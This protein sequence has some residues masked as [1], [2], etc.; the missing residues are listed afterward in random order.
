[1]IKIILVEDLQIVR[2]SLYVLLKQHPDLDVIAAV[3]GAKELLT[4][5]ENGVS[6]DIVISDVSMPEM[7][8]IEMIAAIKKIKE[9]MH[10]VMLSILEDEKFAA[11][12]FVAGARGYL[13]K[14]VDEAELLFAL[15]QVMAGKRYLSAE[16][17]IGVLER[18]NHQLT[19]MP[20][21]GMPRLALSDR[22]QLVLG[23]IASGMTNQEIAEQVFLSRR[24]V[25]GIRQ[26]LIDRTGAKNSAALIRFA[27][28]N[29]YVS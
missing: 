25:E 14:D 9:S 15:R 3:A 5:L 6:A 23:L 29:G 8:G 16:L 28:L 21:K 12:A 19:N 22:E 27:V 2:R 10:V 4:L 11:K 24:T 13:S 1:M 18:F 7:D 17:S 26:A 20:E